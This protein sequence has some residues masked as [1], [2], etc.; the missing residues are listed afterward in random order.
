MRKP[1]KLPEGLFPVESF[2]NALDATRLKKALA[3][4]ATGHGYAPEDRTCDFPADRAE[5][6]GGP[7]ERFNSIEFWTY[8]GN[9]DVQI[10]FDDFVEH[11][12][13][14][15]DDQKAAD[16]GNADDWEAARIAAVQKVREIVAKAHNYRRD[17]EG[18]SS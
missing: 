3:S 8:A 12:N 4:F 15:V 10:S 17:S 6:E 2:F 7:A 9:E 14:V 18:P 11:L 13:T 16:S 5:E 1:L